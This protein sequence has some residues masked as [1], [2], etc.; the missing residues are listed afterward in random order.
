MN[1][2]K[3]KLVAIELNDNGTCKKVL[4][5]KNLTETEYAKLV[6][7][8]NIS[9]EHGKKKSEKLQNDLSQLFDKDNKLSFLLAKSLYDNL[10]DRG[11]IVANEEF[12]KAF[13]EYLLENKPFE[14][15]YPEEYK[16]ILM[17][18]QEL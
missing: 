7:E 16:K 12:D 18:V 13:E 8:S 10:V 1:N 15:E 4:F 3:T 2:I 11:V 9:K 14:C 17:K 5:V 6:N